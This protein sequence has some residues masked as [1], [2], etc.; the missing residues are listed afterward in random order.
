MYINADNPKLS[1]VL[2]SSEE[3]RGVQRTDD[4]HK[5]LGRPLPVHAWPEEQGSLARSAPE[6]SLRAHLAGGLACI[7]PQKR[8]SASPA[9][10][11][12]RSHL[13]RPAQ[14]R[15][16]QQPRGCTWPYCICIH[17]PNN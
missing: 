12:R 16:A 2:R 13:A 8:A 3:D 9:A 6:H 14:V 1:G 4:L 5:G 10:G 15:W 11:R 7:S 17:L